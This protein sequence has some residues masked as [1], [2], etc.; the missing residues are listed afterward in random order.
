MIKPLS[1]V[2]LNDLA[3]SLL[4]RPNSARP[5]WFPVKSVV[6]RLIDVLELL[7]AVVPR[8]NID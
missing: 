7:I 8:I 2:L 5:D 3:K 4:P 6:V 1:V